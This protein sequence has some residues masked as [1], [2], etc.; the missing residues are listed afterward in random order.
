[1]VIKITK[2]TGISLFVLVDSCKKAVPK[3]A[4]SRIPTDINAYQYWNRKGEISGKLVITTNKD[5]T[6]NDRAPLKRMFLC[7]LV[8]HYKA[9]L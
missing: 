1:M 3:P 9:E 5:T 4:V 2:N 7:F 6:I 8:V